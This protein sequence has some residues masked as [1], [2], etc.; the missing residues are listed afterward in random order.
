MSIAEPRDSSYHTLATSHQALQ[1]ALQT[2]KERCQTFQRRIATLEEENGS[3]RMLQA[4]QPAPNTDQTH[5][6]HT[7]D[8]MHELEQLRMSVSELTHQKMQMTEQISIV[9]TENRQ[10]WRRLSLIMKDLA[11]HSDPL[12]HDPSSPSV[13]AKT[14]PLPATTLPA[15]Q[16]LIRSRTF[17]KHA[18]NPKLRERLPRDGSADEQLINLEDISLLHTCGFLEP[19]GEAAGQ[20]MDP[21]DAFEA[22]PYLSLCTELLLDAQQELALQQQ[23]MKQIYKQLKTELCHRLVP[24]SRI[25][26][27]TL[28]K[29]VTVEVAES[30]LMPVA[31]K[32]TNHHHTQQPPQPAP[33]ESTLI[34]AKAA[35]ATRAREEST[36]PP[37][38]PF[39]AEDGPA[40]D[41]DSLL[42]VMLQEKLRTE[43]KQHVCP[44]CA[45]QYGS[46]ATFD[47]FVRHVQEHFLD[48]SDDLSL[49]RTGEYLSQTVGNF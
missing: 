42:C 7:P 19:T 17:T 26:Q 31:E 24:P 6:K 43:E 16:N 48:E 23:G 30:E 3:L 40:T 25:E 39:T 18:P 27:K 36:P 29:D 44:I 38:L 37:T 45:Q 47:E 4:V 2:L 41:R 8:Q 10:L 21:L 1:A 14:Q 11:P 49:D 22:N 28:M 12:P 32:R 35:A 9:G 5:D 33:R 34:T 13:S 15:G 20:A 46:D